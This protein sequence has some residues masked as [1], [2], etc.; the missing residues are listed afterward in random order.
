MMKAVALALVASL[1]AVPSY[2]ADWPPAD[3][4]LNPIVDCA[5]APSPDMCNSSKTTWRDNYRKAIGGDYQGQRNVSY[6]LSTGCN[7]SVKENALLGCAWRI[8]ILESGHLDADE[9]DTSNA[10][11]YCGPDRISKTALATAQAQARTM[12]KMLAGTN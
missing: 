7:K 8:V 11:F 10:D 9:S 12:L 5:S 4:Y 1:S 2:A 3:N 6:C